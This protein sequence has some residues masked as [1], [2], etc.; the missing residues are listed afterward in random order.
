MSAEEHVLDE[1]KPIVR[2][3]ELGDSSINFVVRMW[4]NTDDYWETY[5]NVTRAVKDQFDEA[6][7]TIPYPQRDVHLHGF[8]KAS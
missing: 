3:H 7:V 8:D 2:V 4:V 6:G 1:P 5:W